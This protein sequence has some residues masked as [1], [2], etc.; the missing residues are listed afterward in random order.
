MDPHN[1]ICTSFFLFVLYIFHM[2]IMYI[3]Y[4]V[5]N[6]CT[7]RYRSRGR[8]PPRG[9][10]L[11]TVLYAVR[12]T[13]AQMQIS[14][15]KIIIKNVSAGRRTMTFGSSKQ[16]LSLSSS[17]HNIFRHDIRDGKSY[18]CIGASISL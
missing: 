14:R 13:I 12:T 9:V 5:F 15:I 17:V 18:W 2:Y 8:A 4:A 3:V 1:T 7:A 16:L 11:R 10:D 6:I